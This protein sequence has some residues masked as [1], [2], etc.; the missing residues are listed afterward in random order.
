MFKGNQNRRVRDISALTVLGQN[1]SGHGN[2]DGPGHPKRLR[3][4]ISQPDFADSSAIRVGSSSPLHDGSQDG[5]DRSSLPYV[6]ASTHY[7][8]ITPEDDTV[9]LASCVIRHI[10]YFA[11]PQNSASNP[12]V[13]EFR[14][15]KT[16]LAATTTTAERRMIAID[17]GGLCLRRQNQDGSFALAKNH[18]AL[19]EAKTQFHCVENGRPVISNRSFAQMVCEA[20]ATRVS[21]MG[22]ESLRR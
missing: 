20:L 14:D 21:N 22:D 4:Q 17:D 2:D 8:S 11:A 5:S 15:A 13:V 10:L 1:E 18:V 19:L 3:R 16:R 9:R 12:V 7:L 6:D